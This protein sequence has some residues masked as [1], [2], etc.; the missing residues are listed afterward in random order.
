MQRW[1][2]CKPMA[3]VVNTNPKMVETAT[4]VARAG[5]AEEG[6]AQSKQEGAF[7]MVVATKR[8]PETAIKISHPS[9]L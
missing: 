6:R 7:R 5:S 2:I 4:K 9:A 3:I 8:A 1:S